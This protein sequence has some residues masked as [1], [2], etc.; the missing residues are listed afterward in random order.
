MSPK[1]WD[2]QN[3]FHSFNQQK[4]PIKF[5]IQGQVPIYSIYSISKNPVN[6]AMDMFF[7]QLNGGVFRGIHLQKKIL[8]GAAKSST[9]N[10]Q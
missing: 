8:G 10:H 5:K 7:S 4:N 6:I 3:K 9:M 1:I 2:T